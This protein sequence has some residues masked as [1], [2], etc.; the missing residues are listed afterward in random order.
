MQAPDNF[1]FMFLLD[2]IIFLIATSRARCISLKIFFDHEVELGLTR[3]LLFRASEIV[4]LAFKWPDCAFCF[5]ICV[6]SRLRKTSLS[7]LN[8]YV[9]A[10]QHTK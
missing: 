3:Y 10:D 8:F 1:I 2:F 4:S 7:H 9:P 5:Q 6:N